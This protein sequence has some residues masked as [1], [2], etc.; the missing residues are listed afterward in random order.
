MI[1]FEFSDCS[2]NKYVQYYMEIELSD[3]TKTNSNNL[4]LVFDYSQKTYSSFKPNLLDNEYK[5]EVFTYGK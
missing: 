4:G 2:I 5:F 3:Y 1:A